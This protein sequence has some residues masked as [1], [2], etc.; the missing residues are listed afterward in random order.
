M[1]GLAT[2]EVQHSPG[3]TCIWTRML[4]KS[5]GTSGT[6]NCSKNQYYINWSVIPVGMKSVSKICLRP[7]MPS[8]GL[9]DT[10]RCSILDILRDAPPW[11]CFWLKD[12]N[13]MQ[14]LFQDIWW[15]QLCTWGIPG[16]LFLDFLLL[17]IPS[18]RSK[19]K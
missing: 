14:R 15:H 13:I 4:T 5:S 19:I 2:H 9:Q 11:W 6:P 18:Y 8:W 17:L 3:L 16:V 10:I 7:S 1:S 12:R